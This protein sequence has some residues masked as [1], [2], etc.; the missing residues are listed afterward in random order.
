MFSTG[1]RTFFYNKNDKTTLKATLISFASAKKEELN[2]FFLTKKNKKKN[3]I[4]LLIIKFLF[5]QK[6]KIKFSR[7][8]NKSL[9]YFYI[10]IF[11]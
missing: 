3:I 7:Q 9:F 4:I 1:N 5:S 2:Q 6:N 10:I 8:K 11:Y